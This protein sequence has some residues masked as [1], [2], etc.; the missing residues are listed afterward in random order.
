MLHLAR[1]TRRP[2]SQARTLGPWS[3]AVELV[4]ARQSAAAAR[5]DKI[6][7]AAKAVAARQGARPVTTCPGLSPARTRARKADVQ[8]MGGR[9]SYV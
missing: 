5:Q 7:E 4:N 9:L 8:P 2:A 3:S 6:L 1:R